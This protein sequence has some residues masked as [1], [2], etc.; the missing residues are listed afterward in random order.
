MGQ[1]VEVAQAT[2]IPEGESKA[3]ELNGEPI[4]LFNVD[5][6][7]YAMTNGCPHAGAPLS[8]GWVSKG[9][10]VCPW[11]GWTFELEPDNDPCDGVQRYPVHVE[12]GTIFLEM[13]DD[14]K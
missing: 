14:V 5:G 3:V 1:R 2:D 12:N 9:E 13:P 11:H 10:V 8:L 6:R 4:A 7:I